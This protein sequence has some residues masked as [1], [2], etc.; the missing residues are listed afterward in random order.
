MG[1]ATALPPC[2]RCPVIGIALV[3]LLQAV[4]SVGQLAVAAHHTVIRADRPH[5]DRPARR[6]AAAGHRAMRW[7]SATRGRLP[8][9]P[10]AARLRPLP[11]GRRACTARW[12]MWRGP[13]YDAGIAD[14]RWRRVAGQQRRSP[15]LVPGA[16][17]DPDAEYAAPPFTTPETNVARINILLTGIDSARTRTNE[18]T[19]TLMVV[20]HRPDDRRRRAHQLPARHHALPALDGGTYEGKINSFMT[21]ATDASQ[22]IPRGHR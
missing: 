5:P 19:D 11:R 2:S 7:R 16:S 14:L 12:A 22:G 18:L 4:G 3:L 17:V 9:W 10:T 1:G 8:P 6:L 20:E 13:F 15:S 21:Y